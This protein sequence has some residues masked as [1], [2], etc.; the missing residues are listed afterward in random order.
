MAPPRNAAKITSL[1]TTHLKVKTWRTLGLPIPT[2][3][4]DGTWPCMVFL[5]ECVNAGSF[6]AWRAEKAR[7]ML[8]LRRLFTRQHRH[9]SRADLTLT[10]RLFLLRDD[11]LF[12]RCLEYCWFLDPWKRYPSETDYRRAFGAADTE[13]ES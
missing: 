11:A 6:K 13:P 10:H 5:L 9:A 2:E 7:E 4:H 1:A 3:P 8:F 12:L